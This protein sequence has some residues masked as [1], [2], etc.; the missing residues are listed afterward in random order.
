MS[1]SGSSRVSIRRK[2]IESAI[3][4]MVKKAK[5]KEVVMTGEAQALMVVSAQ[6][7][8]LMDLIGDLIDEISGMKYN[9]EPPGD[10]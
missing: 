10:F 9:D 6:I 8:G 7:N 4:S 1:G 3:D 2:E 5:E